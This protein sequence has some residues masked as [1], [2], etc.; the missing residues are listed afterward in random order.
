MM[1][2]IAIGWEQLVFTVCWDPCRRPMPNLCR[3]LPLHGT[4]RRHLGRGGTNLCPSC[5]LNITEAVRAHL[6]RCPMLPSAI[7]PRAQELRDAGQRLVKESQQRRDRSDVLMREAEAALFRAQRALREAM[8]RRAD[9]FS[10][11]PSSALAR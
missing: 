7:R 4:C 2:V 5:R 10:C 11:I 1:S 9:A 3:Q 8:P 6:F